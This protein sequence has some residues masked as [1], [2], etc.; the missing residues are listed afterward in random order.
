M[1]KCGCAACQSIQ[2]A[3]C[4]AVHDAPALPIGKCNCGVMGVMFETRPSQGVLLSM[5]V[6]AILMV[7]IL[8]ALFMT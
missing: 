3:S 5:M 8:V 1:T 7:I 4:C 2:H 6:A